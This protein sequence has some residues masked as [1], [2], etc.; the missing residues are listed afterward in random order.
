MSV[1]AIRRVPQARNEPVKSYAPGSAE[2]IELKARL[3]SMASERID[4]PVVVDGQRIKTGKTFTAVSPHNHRHVLADCHEA[5]AAHVQAAI[6]ASKRAQ[7][8][9]SAWPFE[10]RAAVIMR[11]A[12]L[13]V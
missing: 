10:E 8:E 9:W 5:S 1:T 3:K 11:A 2:R 4:I 12:D 7:R 13:L 6:D